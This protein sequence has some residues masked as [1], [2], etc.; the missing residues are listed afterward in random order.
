MKRHPAK[1]E[2]MHYAESL[3]ARRPIPAQLGG[4]IAGCRQCQA[5]VAAIQLSLSFVHDAPPCEP[6]A[7][8]T[9]QL[10][11][12]AR[13]ER[14]A[15]RRKPRFSP[16]RALVRTAAYAAALAVV[17]MVSY[18]TALH[19]VALRPDAEASSLP[20]S[21]AP[22]ALSPEA[23][24]KAA[25]EIQALLPALS[26]PSK[27]PPSLWE[28]EHRRAVHAL[29][30]DIE[31]ARAALERNPGCDRATRIVD[32]NLQRQAQALKALYVERSL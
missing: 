13:S 15:V 30:R 12:A 1:N 18:G 7:D 19:S 10:L 21:P 24:A 9:Q 14:M 4:H 2:L 23:I 17:C 27:T 22:P 29:T 8:F 25:A 5:E 3:V 6:T 26:L 11:M 20:A 32:S 31:A 16:L 28:M